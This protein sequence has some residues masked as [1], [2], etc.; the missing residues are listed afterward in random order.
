[1]ALSITSFIY[2]P[3]GHKIIPYLDVLH[4]TE[5]HLGEKGFQINPK[6]LSKQLFYFTVTAQ[7]V[8]F[9][10]ETIVP[11]AK[12]KTFAKVK[13]VQVSK[14]GQDKAESEDAA[15][16]VEFLKRVRKEAQLDDYDVTDDL[17]EMV[18]QFGYLSLFSVVWP[19]VGCSFLVNNWVEVRSDAM[20][21]AVGSQRPIPWRGDS[22]GPWLNSLGFLSWLGSI[23]SAALVYM[24]GGSS[25]YDVKVSEVTGWMLLLS[26]LLAEHVYLAVQYI[27][28]HALEKMD[29]PGVQKEK[30]IRFALRK[31]ILQESYGHE[32]GGASAGA[33]PE[34]GE[35]ITI[36]TIGDGA[37]A[38][39]E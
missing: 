9:A 23:T 4:L 35:S 6:R 18:M 19:L 13:E 16:E 22:I 17:R 32:I 27:V 8:N 33:G 36:E 34:K 29:S 24:Y 15:E 5:K 26:I 7:I 37:Q 10:L 28:R 31:R 30:A 14:K 12:R 3:F 38:Q 25:S 2:L 11:Y 1:M 21:I 20:K 39:S